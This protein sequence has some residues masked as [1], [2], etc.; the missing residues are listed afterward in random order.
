MILC[1]AGMPRSGTSLVTQLLHRAGLDLGERQD[2]MPASE[3]NTDGY[4][5]NLR[6]VHINDRLLTA[7]GG[8]WFAP[9]SSLRPTPRLD[10]DARSLV[11]AFEGML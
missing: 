9:P 11:A 2:L 4:W 10:A 7:S 8:T 6:F 5:E 1:I 3:N